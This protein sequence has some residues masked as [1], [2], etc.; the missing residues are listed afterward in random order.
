MDESLR[1][2]RAVGRGAQFNPPNPFDRCRHEAD[3]S[4]LPAEDAA[5]DSG[6]RIPTQY[7]PDDAQSIVSENDSPD[8]PFRYSLNPYRGCLH[9]CSY[10]YAR[11]YHEYLGMSAGLDFETKIMVKQRAAELFR[12]WLARPQYL[13]ET[14]TLSGVTDCYQPGERR[15]ELTRACL[16]VAAEC[17]QPLA[18]ITKNALVTRDLDLLRQMAETNTIQVGLSLTS[19]DQ[20]LTAVME[21]RTSSPAARLR[22]VEHLRSAEIPVHVMLAPLIPGLND[23][24]IPALLKAARDAGAQAASFTLLRLPKTVEPIFRDWL[25]RHFP[26]QQHRIESRIRTTR[27]GKLNDARFGSR[28]SGSGVFAE[29]LQ[30]T[31]RLFANQLGLARRLPELNCHDFRPPPPP[32]GQLRLF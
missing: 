30:Q 5:N 10:C 26:T 29:H 28:M 4:Q 6:R 3:W 11:P 13:P 9:G 20:T 12:Q 2:P 18:V 17:R 19:L 21:P 16:E 32:S 24:E 23:S 22:A 27:E 25:S 7:L 31:F 1:P 8:I 14:I 15:F